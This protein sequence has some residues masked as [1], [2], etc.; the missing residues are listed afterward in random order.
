[1]HVHEKEALQKITER[2]REQFPGKISA[3]LAFG[4]RVRGDHGPW[5]DFDVLVVVRDK[6]A[7]LEREII[8]YF[9][10]REM[11]LGVSFTPVIKDAAAFDL[12]KKHHTPFYENLSRE[13]VLI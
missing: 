11:E 1:M 12:E 5:S 10:D 8:G 6:T 2:L 13:G 4:S 7:L 3:V 9:V